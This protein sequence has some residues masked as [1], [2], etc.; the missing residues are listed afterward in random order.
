MGFMDGL[1]RFVS[2]KPIFETPQQKNAPGLPGH[3]G[4]DHASGQKE[5]P[6]VRIEQSDAHISGHHMRLVCEIK[7]E[8]SKRLELDKIL[9]FGSSKE[10]DTWLN[11]GESRQLI[12]FEGEMPKHKNNY[13]SEVWFRDETGDYF[14]ALHVVEFKQENDG[15]YSVSRFRSIGPMKDI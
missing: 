13:K 6:E 4:P 12:V 9:L 3:P 2:G 8:S 5:I 11:P 7:N 10:L 15:H 14:S 1:G